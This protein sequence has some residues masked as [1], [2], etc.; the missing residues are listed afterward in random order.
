[1]AYRDR[2]QGFSFAYVD[3]ET[4]FAQKDS[5]EFSPVQVSPETKT[6]NFNKDVPAVKVE[7][8]K[9][10]ENGT[11]QIKENFDRLQ[12]LHQK[13]HVIL[14]ELNQITDKDPKKKS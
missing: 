3:L 5:L 1:M 10:P 9:M 14:A 8:E 4:L 11:E 13:L 7:E 12:V 2:S 6:V